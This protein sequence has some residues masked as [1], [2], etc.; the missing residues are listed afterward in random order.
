MT[1]EGLRLPA[2]EVTVFAEDYHFCLHDE[3]AEIEWSETW[4]Q[5]NFDNMLSVGHLVVGVGTARDKDVPVSVEVVEKE[6]DDDDL[7]DWDHV[8][9]CNL[10]LPSGKMLISGPTE[11]LDLAARI[12]VEPGMYRMR[13]YYGALEEVDD[14]GFEGDDFY[15][16]VLWRG[17]IAQNKVIK[18]WSKL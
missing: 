3:K 6:P 1:N 13:I 9:E 5:D 15:R 10:E 11:S 7:S 17:K 14:D 4:E 8:T 2:L 12:T 18:R 16:V